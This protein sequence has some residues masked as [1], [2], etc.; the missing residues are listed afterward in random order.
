MPA[1]CVDV[2]PR[3]VRTWDSGVTDGEAGGKFPPGSSNV[4]PFLEMPPLLIQFRLPPK[5]FYKLQTFCFRKFVFS[6]LCG[7]VFQS[8]MQVFF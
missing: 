6:L 7:C 8:F 3:L 1:M 2:P 4:G 5:Q